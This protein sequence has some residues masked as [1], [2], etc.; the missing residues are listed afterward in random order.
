MASAHPFVS[1]APPNPVDAYLQQLAPGSRRVM[2]ASLERIADA[3]SQGRTSAADFP[4]GSST[5]GDAVRLRAWL[6]RGPA[7]A[8]AARHLCAWRCVLR[9]AWR[10]G[11]MPTD[12]Y[13]RARDVRAPRRGEQRRGRLLRVE[14]VAAL[15]NVADPSPF[16]IRD[17]AMV[18]VLCGCGLRRAELRGLDTADL[19]ARTGR[20][21]V[22]TAKG[23]RPR[24]LTLPAPLRGQVRAWLDLR[25]DSD[26]PLFTPLG[27]TG[28]LLPRRLSPAG[29][30][31]ALGRLA[32]Q[33]RVAP[34]GP[35]SLR[36]FYATELV[37]RG[38]DLLTVQRLMGHSNLETLRVYLLQVNTAP[39][40]ADALWNELAPKRLRV[41]GT[42]A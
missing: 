28:R 21:Y 13:L 5:Y 18:A 10:L 1:P 19:D 39:P 9:E 41:A 20:L 12:Q 14:E 16:D 23:G 37:N 4:W 38:V 6:A 26:G 11:L 17:V 27:P 42:A 32:A 40:Q 3:L 8:T 7:P 35:H 24:E 34:F 25:S 36:R 29:I 15:L 30:V 31:K 22:R 33:Q 2:R